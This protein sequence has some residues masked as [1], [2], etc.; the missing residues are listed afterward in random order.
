MDF[1]QFLQAFQVFQV[2][3]LLQVIL[4]G[5]VVTV[6]VTL[7]EGCQRW[8]SM[9]NASRCHYKGCHELDSICRHWGQHND[10]I[11]TDLSKIYGVYIGITDMF[12]VMFCSFGHGKLS[13][14]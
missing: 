2:I 3:T 6:G 7:F 11:V 8:A 13:D 4:S 10:F 14:G 12:F 1:E 9:L 5:F